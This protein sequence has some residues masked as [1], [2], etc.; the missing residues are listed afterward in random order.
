MTPNPEWEKEKR[1]PHPPCA[2]KVHRGRGGFVFLTDTTG[3]QE[4]SVTLAGTP[5]G[6]IVSL[7]VGA[8]EPA[9][10]AGARPLCPGCLA[11][12]KLAAV[13]VRNAATFA[14]PVDGQDADLAGRNDSDVAVREIPN[15]AGARCQTLT[16]DADALA[17]GDYPQLAA[18]AWQGGVT[19]TLVPAPD[20]L[21][22]PTAIR[23]RNLLKFALRTQALRATSIRPA[24][25]VQAGPAADALTPAP[26]GDDAPGG[27]LT[28]PTGIVAGGQA[29]PLYTPVQELVP[30]QRKTVSYPSETYSRVLRVKSCGR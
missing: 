25:P 11:L 2:P 7:G 4:Q 17:V 9:G 19:V 30:R 28:R 18:D 13:G 27:F 1:P 14:V 23:L 22:R 26:G 8:G 3:N 16:P 21:H 6:G 15:L 10:I 29:P 5:I 20:H 24:V 12:R